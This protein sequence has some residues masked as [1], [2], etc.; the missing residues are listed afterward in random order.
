MTKD[1]RDKHWW[2]TVPGFLKA[3]A[4]L[5]T[6]IGGFIAVMYQVGY[7]G[8]PKRQAAPIQPSKEVSH[9]QNMPGSPSGRYF[10]DD[11]S[12][13]MLRSEW[14]VLEADNKR[15]E[16]EANSQKLLI[17]T[18][19][20][21]LS[22]SGKNLKNQ[23]ILN[24]NLPEDD[25]EVI[26]KASIQIQSQHNAMSIALFQDDDNFLEL[27]YSGRVGPIN[28]TF[29]MR[30][31]HFAKEID[32]RRNVLLGE[33]PRWH[34]AES[35]ETMFL[36]IERIGSEYNGYYSIVK[37]QAV[38]EIEDIRWTKI[39]TQVWSGLDGKLSIW[40]DNSN[41]NITY[42]GPPQE[43]AVRIDFV[44]IREVER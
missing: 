10:F 37:S 16:I 23:F 20:G 29:I 26:V 1:P 39:G 31:P 32:G 13:P 17:I 4:A 2:Q 11:F 15:W 6:A 24:L 21:T 27:G 36:R 44:T 43:V 7:L 12:T 40:A 34:A 38:W 14:T 18:Q 19:K 25:Y 42:G 35:P 9:S 5:I 30:V 8:G 33:E 28:N 3:I 22:E 41:D